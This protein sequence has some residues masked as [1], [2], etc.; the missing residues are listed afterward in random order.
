MEEFS[1]REELARMLCEWDCGGPGDGNCNLGNPCEF[2]SDML[3][4]VDKLL[5]AL[6]E[7]GEGVRAAGLLALVEV[8]E[9]EADWFREPEQQENLTGADCPLMPVVLLTVR[10]STETDAAWKAAIAHIK[11]Q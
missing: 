11:D 9:E 1:K 5:D 4:R 7:P 6:M 3:P 2:W 8:L 10:S